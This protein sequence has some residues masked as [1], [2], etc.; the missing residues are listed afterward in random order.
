VKTKAKQVPIVMV[1]VYCEGCDMYLCDVSFY[2]TVSVRCPKCGGWKQ[3]ENPK[4]AH[5]CC[6]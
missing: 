5:A 6:Q 4:L 1:P 3:P 2:V